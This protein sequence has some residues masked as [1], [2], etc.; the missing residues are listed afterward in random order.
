MDVEN[1]SNL[2]PPSDGVS[3]RRAF[4]VM[5]IC[6]GLNH[7]AV[8]IPVAYG[9]SVY[10]GT[11]GNA[12]N[13]CLYGVCMLSALFLG[14]LFTNSLG[15]K[16][17]LVLGM[18]FY[19]IYVFLFAIG[20]NF[21]DDFGEDGCGAGLSF[22]EDGFGDKCPQALAWICAVGGGILGGL[23]AG[24]LWTAQGAFFG[25]ICEEIS[26]A[27][28]TTLGILTAQLSS[29]F[30]IIFLG[31]ECLWKVLF[32]LLTKYAELEFLVAFLIYGAL[33]SL[34]T[35]GMFFGKDARPKVSATAQPLCAK[36]SAALNLWSDP[37]IWL[38][39]GNNI[40]FGFCA[41]YL[42][43]YVN[44]NYTSK[45]P[46]LGKD[47]LGFLGA[48][49]AL[50]ATLSSKMYGI[51]A[52]KMG[53]KVPIILTGSLC[54]LGIA[55]LSLITA[56]SCDNVPPQFDAN[57]QPV[58]L[59]GPACWGWGLVVFYVLQGLGRGVYESTNKA[60]FADFFPGEK[61]VGG[62]ANCI[63]QN[64]GSS[65]IGF[66]MGTFHVGKWDIIPLIIGA[67]ATVPM[68]ALAT[69]MKQNE[70]TVVAEN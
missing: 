14:P 45:N 39:S 50:I 6:F 46:T 53:T 51:L 34:A 20:L 42:N 23:G 7:A 11:V 43:G 8:T 17:A 26:D 3:A 2:I 52:E 61:S 21:V 32:T 5:C 15:P 31:Q 49:V 28:G 69:Q 1:D 59:N 35:V 57:L 9:S 18:L 41:A 36:A 70:S 24:S 13:A 55:L 68:L 66:I 19:C 25:A 58:L 54:F 63:L 67:V 10:G 40:T 60:I 48:I 27:T 65:T 44:A 16:N 37:K 30:A 56:P 4:M 62:F 38:V 64:T 33:A 29:T 22:G 47:F 12:S